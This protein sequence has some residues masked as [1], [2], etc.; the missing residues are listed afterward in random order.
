M[1][2]KKNSA[3]KTPAGSIAPTSA[4]TPQATAKPALKISIP[5]ILLEDDP[6]PSTY[7]KGAPKIVPPIVAEVP[8]GVVTEPAKQPPIAPAR[9]VTRSDSE[10]ISLGELRL[11]ARDPY[12]LFAQWDLAE[13]E[14]NRARGQAADGLIVL[15]V[16][17][18]SVEGPVVVEIPVLG[19][20][21]HEFI[22]V[23]HAATPY[24]C[25]LGYRAV[26]GRQW[27]SLAQSETVV[28][29]PDPQA[30]RS[31]TA[32]LKMGHWSAL[33]DFAFQVKE[34]PVESVARSVAPAAM[35]PFFVAQPFV[36]VP[37]MVQSHVENRLHVPS[38]D[39]FTA[40][41]SAELIHPPEAPWHHFAVPSSAVPVAELSHVA[42]TDLPSSPVVLPPEMRRGF[43]FAVNAEVV[44]YGST[45][46]DA[47]VTMAGRSIKL[48]ADGSFS[49]RF[50]LPDGQFQLPITAASADGVERRGA[51]LRLSRATGISGEVGTHPQDK[52]LRSPAA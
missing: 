29:A 26:E 17:R 20:E 41:S 40:P 6:D 31:A 12:T 8:K 34:V 48:R 1:K 46:P 42:A 44:V 22:P 43:W 36:A 5:P 35:A 15:R 10:T 28:T 30:D 32:S 14:L 3:K 39:P 25:Q 52:S 37:A 27:F 7:R 9:V 23:P 21:R 38:V 33:E 18:R 50:S 24:A 2:S 13:S 47:A 19:G 51:E 4:A 11:L 45:E 16:H 49:F